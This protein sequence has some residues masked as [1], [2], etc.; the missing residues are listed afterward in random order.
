MISCLPLCANRYLQNLRWLKDDER[1]LYNIV[2]GLPIIL[3][4]S[5]DPP[6]VLIMRNR[7]K[8]EMTRDILTVSNGGAII[9]HIMFKAYA[10]HAQA[11]SYLGELI[12][13]GF[14]V[15]DELDRK[16]RTTAKGLEYLQAMESISE[17][18]CTNTKRSTPN[19]NGLEVHQFWEVYVLTRNLEPRIS[20]F[21]MIGSYRYCIYLK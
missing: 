14:V 13:N 7:Q 11:K 12:E 6:S 1:Q 21:W 4:I 10:S 17:M 3:L 20:F 5:N 15:Y 19:Q 18:F 8:D 2:W 16:Y 9:S